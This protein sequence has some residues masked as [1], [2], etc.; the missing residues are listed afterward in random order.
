MSLTLH[1]VDIYPDDEDNHVFA[2]VFENPQKLN[3]VKSVESN[4]VNYGGHAWS[5]I[6]MRREDR[7]L[8]VFLKW[9]Y[10]DGTSCGYVTAKV[11]KFYLIFPCFK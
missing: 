6:C 1:K 9:H 2:F 5:I 11:L 10:P 7:H 4:E 3:E 8:G